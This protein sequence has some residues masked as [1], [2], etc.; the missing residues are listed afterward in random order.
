[1]CVDGHSSIDLPHKE[2]KEKKWH[3]LAKHFVFQLLA[4][5]SSKLSIFSFPP[6]VCGAW[7]FELHVNCPIASHKKD[8]GLWQF[9]GFLRYTLSRQN[10]CL[11][12]QQWVK[13]ARLTLHI[14]Q[15]FRS[16]NLNIIMLTSYN[17]GLINNI[18]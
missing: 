11:P 9:S 6:T 3:S 14:G 17:S 12:V 5:W 18:F 15:T 16:T 2:R 4:E 1:M 13:S 8:H 7:G 10:E